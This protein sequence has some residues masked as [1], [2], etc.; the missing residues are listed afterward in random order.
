MRSYALNIAFGL[1]AMLAGGAD[2]SAGSSLH[3]VNRG[4]VDYVP[5]PGIGSLYTMQQ[6]ARGEEII[7]R[8]QWRR[9][10]V[11]TDSRRARLDGLS[12]WL[13]R[14]VRSVRGSWAVSREDFQTIIDPVMRPD[15]H[16]QG[17]RCRTVVLDPGHGGK[18]KGAV[19]RRNVWEKLVV[20]DVARRA[21]RHL[22]REGLRV[23]KTRNDD[24][25]V[26]LSDRVETAR[27]CD[28]DLF[29][30]I[31]MNAAHDKSV[32]GTET[33]VLTA[34]GESSTGSYGH[35]GGTH[36][37][38]RY[39]APSAILGFQL[40]RSLVERIRRPDRGLKRARFA[41]LRDAP[42]P[43]ALVEGAFV[44]NAT[45]EDLMIDASFR[46]AMARGIADG[47]LRYA[48]LV[49]RAGK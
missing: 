43:A 24:T 1:L 23:V 19:G 4:G 39:D 37:G 38:N 22:R 9:I 5:L 32:T 49:R 33:Y 17:R 48:G 10:A 47:I 34:G 35:F 12:V 29:V 30:S 2:A 25:Y 14:P 44:S 28:A 3:T 18:D 6:G 16:L 13:H 46:E 26:S 45:E 27:Q 11:E 7:L 31:H 40:H 20:M 21:E 42:C 15:R 8:N 36:G 41:I